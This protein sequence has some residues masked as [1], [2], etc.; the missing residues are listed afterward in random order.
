MKKTYIE[1][2]RIIAI[3][4]VIYNHTR[5]LG[6]TLYQYTSDPCSYY[7]SVLI[8]PVCKTAVPLFLMISGATLLG[9]EEDYKYLFSR[10]IVRYVGIILFW[11]SLQYCRYV[12]TGKAELSVRG[13]WNN[14][15]SSP[16]L[17]TYWYLYLYLGF[18]ILLPLLRKTVAGMRDQD[19]RYLFGLSCVGSVLTMF[20]Y[21]SGC[22]INGSIFLL[23]SV[24]LY[25][26]LGYWIDKAPRHND[27]KDAL[28]YS[29]TAILPLCV[30][31]SACLI[32]EKNMDLNGDFMDAIQCLT[33]MIS[34]GIFG[35]IKSMDAGHRHSARLKKAVLAVGDT[36]FGIYLTEDMI[37]NQ[38]FK[39]IVHIHANDFILAV[40]YTLLT[41]IL[42]VVFIAVMKKIPI[43]KRLI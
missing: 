29:L 41:F 9:K 1:C 28:K 30:I 42:G 34:F 6:F 35:L 27:R 22:F 12:R 43:L 8:M 18:L 5:E 17:E 7:L 11:G 36:V 2:L 25:P 26:L 4:L 31:V 13:W 39:L 32:F 15:Y 19:Y 38:V 40:L 3:I 37:R 24:F 14:I 23:P 21:F 20:G 10:R 33:P 16:K